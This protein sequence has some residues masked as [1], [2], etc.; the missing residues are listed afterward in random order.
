MRL[1]CADSV[2]LNRGVLSNVRVAPRKA[3]QDQAH[4]AVFSEDTLRHD[5]FDDVR[6]IFFDCFANLITARC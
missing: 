3:F 1:L 2:G 4:A 5:H 6:E